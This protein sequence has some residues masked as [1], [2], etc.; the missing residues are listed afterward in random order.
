MAESLE[1]LIDR[2]GPIHEW[3]QWIRFVN[4]WRLVSETIEVRVL[5]DLALRCPN[6]KVRE[7]AAEKF[8]KDF[9]IARLDHEWPGQWC[10]E[11]DWEGLTR[12]VETKGL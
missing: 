8:G 6:A 12:L 2:Y 10:F 5:I 9:A 3:D 11:Y 7:K 1:D 4:K